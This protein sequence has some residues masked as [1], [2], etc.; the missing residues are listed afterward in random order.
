MVS[1]EGERTSE[2]ETQA[3]L[4]I[5]LLPT[6]LGLQQEVLLSGCS[7]DC[8]TPFKASKDVI[9]KLPQRHTEAPATWSETAMPPTGQEITGA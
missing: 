5:D 9:Q 2:T 8:L 7:W 1:S 3:E 6:T 4:A